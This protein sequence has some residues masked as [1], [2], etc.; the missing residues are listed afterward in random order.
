MYIKYLL[1][2]YFIISSI[3]AEQI[4]NKVINNVS[5]C[6]GFLKFIWFN[7]SKG[8]C[9]FSQNLDAVSAYKRA[10]TDQCKSQIADLAC[11]SGN[12]FKLNLRREFNQETKFYHGCINELAFK[13]YLNEIAPSTK[14]STQSVQFC[15]DFCLTNYHNKVCAYKKLTNECYCFK[16]SSQTLIDPTNCD[17]ESNNL[18]H[19]Y[20][21]GMIGL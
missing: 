17:P 19:F 10:K 11:D 6:N 1:L 2:V 7:S 12:I 8:P 5:N 16:N 20:S 15:I 9:D 4:Y 13:N 21:T 3:H 14:A 18:I